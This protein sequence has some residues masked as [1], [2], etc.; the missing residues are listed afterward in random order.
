[1][2]DV[3]RKKEYDKG[4]LPLTRFVLSNELKY[5]VNLKRYPKASRRLT[6]LTIVS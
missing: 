2:I 6:Y 4:S 1:M 3:D 5:M